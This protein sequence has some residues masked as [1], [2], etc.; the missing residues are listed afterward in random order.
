MEMPMEMR[1]YDVGEL[2]E[3]WATYPLTIKGYRCNYNFMDSLRS[4][5]KREHNEYWMIWS[6]IVPLVIYVVLTIIYFVKST[7][8]K[9]DVIGVFVGIILCRTA[10]T[11]YHI[12]NSMNL[13]TSQ[14]LVNV[15]LIGITCMAFTAPYFYSLGNLNASGEYTTILFTLQSICVIMFI[16]NMI[17][18]ETE[19]TREMRDPALVILALYANW[20]MVCIILNETISATVKYLCSVSVV[21]LL[22][23]YVACFR[24]CI[25]EVL[26]GCE[27]VGDGK[28]WNSHVIW[29]LSLFVSHMCLICVVMN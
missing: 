14:R 2:P 4:T 1:C 17:I 5:I 27:G 25:P 8:H 24:G 7:E 23:G 13:W 20:S 29:H 11:I 18:G 16:S 15:D 19:I 26:C 6:D 22:V 12:F 3:G 10:S 21:S 28:I 9:I